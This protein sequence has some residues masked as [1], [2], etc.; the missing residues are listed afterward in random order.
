[1]SLETKIRDLA[2]RIATEINTIRTERGSLASLTT[3]EKAS[4]VG[5]INELKTAVDAASGATINDSGTGTSDA[6]SADK[7]ATEITNAINGVV[8][9]AGAAYDTLSELA[10]ALTDNDSDI[11][12]ILTSLSNRVR[13]DT[14][15]S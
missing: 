14:A 2:T 3:T 5:A 13:T 4:I 12:G 8:N 10:T 1:M 6:W 15:R 9:G 11:S 7:I